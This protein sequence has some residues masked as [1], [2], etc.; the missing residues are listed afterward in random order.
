MGEGLLEFVAA[1]RRAE[2]FITSKVWN[3]DHRPADVRASCEASLS[4]LGVAYLDLL[5]LHWPEAWLPSADFFS[6]TA[7]PGD[8]EVTLLE[9]WY[10][11]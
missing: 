1:G 11:A 7:N 10:V 2:L 6:K 9:M 8:T 3:T 4:Q 5:L